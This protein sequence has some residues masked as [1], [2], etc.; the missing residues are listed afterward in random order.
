MH[1]VYLVHVFPVKGLSTG[2]SGNY[3]ANMAQIM[4]RQGH[5]VSIITESKEKNMI[6]WNGID[7]YY[8]C[9]TRGFKDNKKSMSVYQKVIK[10]LWR[11][12]WYNKKVIE[13]NKKNKVDIVQSV[14]TYAIGLLRS[15]KIPYIT[16]LSSYAPLWGGAEK[17]IFDFKECM[18]SHRLDEELQLLAIKNTD[19]IIAPSQL[20]GNI[21]SQK[22]CKKIEI[23]ESPVIVPEEASLEL[24]EEL[25]SRNKYFV[26]YGSLSNRKSIHMVARIID[27]ILEKFPDMKYV[28][29]GRDRLVRHNGGYVN[30][31]EIF[32]ENIS[33]HKDRFVFMGEISDRTRL[34]SIVYNASCCI[35]P[36][37]IDN[38]PN[39][40]LEAMALGKIVI[41]SNNTS[42]EQ[43][44]T[45][46]YNGFLVKIDDA[47]ELYQK[48]IEVMQLSEDRKK[49]IE[50]RAQERVK[51]LVPDKVYDKMISVY[52]RVITDFIS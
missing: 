33:C 43:L 7:I 39:T 29:I 21:T 30:G 26:T 50:D 5:K 10:N 34:F 37:R 47:S 18:K 2:G 1:I 6:T 12:F 13:I 17:E 36:T 4:Q 23:I 22:I 15:Y 52:E 9:A 11:S 28:V 16:R 40:V 31:S 25:L 32:A 49:Y 46:G 51:N 8:I 38:L 19:I 48:L 20:I 35:L 42:V 44:I 24:K 3:V 14:N 27:D 41:S 45:D